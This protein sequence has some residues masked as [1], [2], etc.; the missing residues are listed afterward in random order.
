M[1]E[2]AAA[3]A[4]AAAAPV[5]PAPLLAARDV[6]F[7]YDVEPILDRVTLEVGA[8]DFLAIVGPN[9]GGKTTLMKVLLGLLEPQSGRVERP[10]RPAAIGYVPQFASGVPRLGP[11]V[12]VS[13]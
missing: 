13:A 2:P 7:A 12:A 9:G 11:K 8:R 4:G 3:S 10:S 1:A 6:T 5:P